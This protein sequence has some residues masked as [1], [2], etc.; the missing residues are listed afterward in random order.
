[1]SPAAFNASFW[2]CAY[3][4]IVKQASLWPLHGAIAATGT[5]GY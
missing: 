5:P 3:S 1:V 4:R 2:E